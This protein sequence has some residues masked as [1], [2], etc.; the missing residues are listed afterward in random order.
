M[1]VIKNLSATIYGK[2][3]FENLDVVVRPGEKVGI[4][5]Q[6]GSVKSTLLKLIAGQIE[7]DE[8][9]ITLDHEIVGY[10]PQS[11]DAAN[12]TTIENY[13]DLPS[14]PQSWALLGK[15]GLGEI[16]ISQHVGA[17]SGGQKTRLALI[18]TL[19]IQPTLLL[20]DEP[21]NNLDSEGTAWLESFIQKF[22]GSA[23]IVS[24][25][26]S[27]LNATVSRIVEFDPANHSVEQYVGN[28]DVYLQE[29]DARRAQWEKDYDLQ[30]REKRR[31]ENWLALKRQEASV[32]VDPAK[33]RQV[34]QMEKRIQ[35]EI[36]DKAIVKPSDNKA[37]KSARFGGST[38]TGKLL[39][40]VE[41][42]G[43]SFEDRELFHDI[44]FEVRG[45]ERLCL[46]GENGS[47]KSTLLKIIMGNITSTAGEARIG[48]NVR[49]GYFSQANDTLNATKTV[50]EEI[51]Y[52][53]P[54]LSLEKA[55][56]VLGGFLFPADDIYKKVGSLSFGERVRLSFAKLMQK[57][58]DLLILDEPTNHLDIPS[59]EAIESAL[60]DYKGGILV[61]SH[62]RYF[63]EQLGEV[64]EF[65]L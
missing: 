10:L 17:L 41:A 11:I 33:G 62:D 40:R 51:Q 45:Q 26:R 53:N 36:Y 35:R 59:R 12:N 39:V 21:T 24:H 25:D 38:H 27:F 20:M 56:S 57:E 29:R 55:R 15:L 28:Y 48:D 5:G 63:L 64:N 60:Q 2:S 50:L 58:H 18:K 46:S 14:Y 8:G 43:K 9:T 44:S 61:V 47:G 19:S 3:L 4:I 34:R 30:Q 16:D 32:Y 37:M 1:I 49:V 22:P 31:L 23:I 52:S 42:L 54:S 7:P 65:A 13:L 6:N